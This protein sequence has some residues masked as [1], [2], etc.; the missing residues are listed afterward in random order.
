[1][2]ELALA[3]AVVAAANETARKNGIAKIT[4]IEVRVG[5]LQQIDPE[6][7]RFAIGEMI[8]AVIDV[9]ADPARFNCR[10]CDRDYGLADTKGPGGHDASEAIH[11]IPELAHAFLRCPSCESPDFTVTGGR[12][13]TLGAIEG[14]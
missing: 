11:F 13:V 5:E 10:N 12:G 1:M 7:F 9:Q 2:H 4:R 14:D 8:E 3:E 6:A